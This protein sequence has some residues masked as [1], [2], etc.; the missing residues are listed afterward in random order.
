MT[1]G[2]LCTITGIPLTGQFTIS[3]PP[4][5]PSE[6]HKGYVTIIRGGPGS[7]QY[8]GTGLWEKNISSARGRASG[9]ESPEKSGY[10]EGYNR[11]R[12]I[13]YRIIRN[14]FPCGQKERQI[15]GARSGFEPG[16]DPLQ[17]AFSVRAVPVQFP[18]P[19]TPEKRI[20][21]SGHGVHTWQHQ[22][23]LCGPPAAPCCRGA[24][25]HEE[26]PLDKA[27]TDELRTCSSTS[28]SLTSTARVCPLRAD[29]GPLS[30]GSGARPVREQGA[31]YPRL[32]YL[33]GTRLH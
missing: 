11:V 28:P 23:R 33:T 16:I 22:S 12:R 30:A 14:Y 18:A 6:G 32:D 25:A 4:A 31:G 19:L 2:E 10:Q 17:Q 21:R 20:C 27:Q 1:A 26:A 5:S 29:R 15:F 9:K 7:M 3:G 24:P 8:P 13:R